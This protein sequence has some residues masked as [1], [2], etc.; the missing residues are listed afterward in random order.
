MCPNNVF[1]PPDHRPVSVSYTE[2]GQRV[3]LDGRAVV[4]AVSDPGAAKDPVHQ[5]VQQKVDG[6]REPDPAAGHDRG[7]GQ[8]QG[9]AERGRDV[10][11]QRRG[12][13]DRDAGAQTRSARAHSARQRYVS[14]P[15]AITT[16]PTTRR[17][18]PAAVP[19]GRVLT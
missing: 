17:S 4:P 18:S 7:E 3:A 10:H 9:R 6:E 15:N 14:P 16:T 19:I 12:R 8:G 5:R 2:P 13:R 11:R 1:V